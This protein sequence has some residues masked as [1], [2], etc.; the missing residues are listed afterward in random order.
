MAIAQFSNTYLACIKS[1]SFSGFPH[2][3]DFQVETDENASDARQLL[4]IKADEELHP[5]VIES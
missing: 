3:T 1:G 5:E 2:E 4:S